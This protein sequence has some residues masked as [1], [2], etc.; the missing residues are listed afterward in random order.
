MVF[1][2]LRSVISTRMGLI[3][4]SIFLPSRL[5]TLRYQI[6]IDQLTRRRPVCLIARMSE[7]LQ[8]WIP[9]VGVL[10]QWDDQAAIN[11]CVDVNVI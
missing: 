2:L 8:A 10:C 4:V 7:Y 3:S 11:S 6:K 5:N 9:S 1:L